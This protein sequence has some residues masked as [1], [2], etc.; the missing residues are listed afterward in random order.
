[1]RLLLLD[2]FD[3]FSHILADYLYRA[4]AEVHVTRNN[5]SLHA[6]NELVKS[7]R[8]EG[9]VLGPGPGLPTQAGILMQVID[10]YIGRL[11]MLG[12]CLGHQALAQCLGGKLVHGLA[13][14]HGKVHQVYHEQQ[15]LFQDIPNPTEVVRY[16]SWVVEQLPDWVSQDAWTRDRELMAFSYPEG[17]VWAV[18]FHPEA[19]LTSHGLQILRNWLALAALPSRH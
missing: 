5:L 13:P 7:Q 4:G 6:F 11:P 16:H 18:Q 8:I 15:G 3:S 2:S 12:V 1:M 14:T 17:Y 19:A 10:H 9:I